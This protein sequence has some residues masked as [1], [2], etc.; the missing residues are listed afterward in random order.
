MAD[1]LPINVT[2]TLKRE[3]GSPEMVR[4]LPL[5][6]AVRFLLKINRIYITGYIKRRSCKSY[7]KHF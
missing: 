4:I 5:K 6:K 1:I 2:S 7:L 3:I